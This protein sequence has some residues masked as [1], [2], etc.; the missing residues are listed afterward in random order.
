AKVLTPDLSTT[1]QLA[2]VA[3]PAEPAPAADPAPEAGKLKTNKQGEVRDSA[4]YTPGG[5]PVL[6]GSGKG[7]NAEDNGIRGWGDGL[8]KLGLNGGP[9]SGA[10]DTKDAGS[11]GAGADG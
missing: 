5:L 11:A 9:D 8:K 2:A 6:F 4:K 3:A 10:G 1:Q 7:K